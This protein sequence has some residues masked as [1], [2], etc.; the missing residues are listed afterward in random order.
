MNKDNNEIETSG[1]IEIPLQ[2][3]NA[4]NKDLSWS[5]MTSGSSVE[6]WSDMTS[7]SSV[8]EDS[9]NFDPSN[10]LDNTFPILSQ[11]SLGM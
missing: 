7:G 11:D 10:S 2:D 1:E 3:E 9:G 4:G 6:D 8:E 5:D